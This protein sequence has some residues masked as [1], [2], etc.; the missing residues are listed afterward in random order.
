MKKQKTFVFT[1]SLLALCLCACNSTSQKSEI[2]SEA[3][4]EKSHEFSYAIPTIN[5]N[6]GDIITF[7]SY[8]KSKVTDG[9]IASN[10]NQIAGSLPTSE[11]SKSWSPYDWYISGSNTI[12]YAWFIDVDTNNDGQNDYRGVYFTSYRPKYVSISSI[13]DNSYQDNYG[14]KLSTVY[15]FKYEPI[16]WRVLEKAGDYFLMSD[17]II[18]SEQFCKYTT[19]PDFEPSYYGSDEIYYKN[20]DLRKFLNND[21]YETAFNPGETSIIKTTV[22][23]N[24]ASTMQ[25]LSDEFACESTNDKV[26]AL[27]YLEATNPSYGFD[28]NPTTDVP[29]TR[30]LI[31]T[32]YAA[33]MGCYV[34]DKCGYWWLRSPGCTSLMDGF[35]NTSPMYEDACGGVVPALR[36][37]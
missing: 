8:P 10:L 24:S 6:K 37:Q 18:D 28:E 17:K 4:S 5:A 29:K 16:E 15:W 2:S 22:V 7:G 36:I 13:T 35:L 33:C 3:S 19:N 34:Y 1:T 31:V 11:D 14:Y 20:S 26:F 23:D 27:S 30:K 25:D 21:F 12:R 32:D 9:S